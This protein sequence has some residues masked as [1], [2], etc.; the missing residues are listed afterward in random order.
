[1]EKILNDLI[2]LKANINEEFIE[3]EKRE[4]KQEI[5]DLNYKVGINKYIRKEDRINYQDVLSKYSNLCERYN[6]LSEYIKITIEYN[7]TNDISTPVLDD[8]TIKICY[9]LATFTNELNCKKKCY[10]LK[11]IYLSDNNIFWLRN[12]DYNI[13]LALFAMKKE[14]NSCILYNLLN[15]IENKE[16]CKY[17][18]DYSKIIDII[19]KYLCNDNDYSILKSYIEENC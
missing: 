2:E 8:T 12:E 13:N 18:Q 6:K 11:M 19:Y 16:V 9:D 1:M 10:Y 4:L 17:K 3:K 15:H 5:K 14:N 7:K